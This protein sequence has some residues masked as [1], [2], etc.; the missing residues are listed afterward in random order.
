MIPIHD[1]NPTHITPWVTFVLLGLCVGAFLGQW[2]L[3]SAAETR[4]LY[5]FGLIPAVFTGAGTLPPSLDVL[6]PIFTV[7]TAVFLHGGILHLLGNLIYLWIFGNN[8][9]DAMGHGRFIVFFA[10]CAFAAAIAQVVA[11]P[12]S[13][14]PM[15]GASGA[16]AG[17][18][19]AYLLLYPNATVT[20]ILH[21]VIIL[22]VVRVPAS[23]LLVVWFAVQII[24]SLF[25]APGTPGVA[26]YAH[27]G[28][29]A[30]G[31]LLIPLFKHDHVP[32]L[33]P[34]SRP[35]HHRSAEIDA[36]GN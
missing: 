34:S 18:L 24:S 14:I 8:I 25:T 21:L 17:I 5:S 6:P 9:E 22:H 16:V 20:V 29:F 31:L 13:Q 26:W 32:L 1:D 30:A 12:D 36:A 19:G 23:W 15:I 27:I 28:G 7:F 4:A 10:L 33:H 2:W 11:A 35:I 3:S